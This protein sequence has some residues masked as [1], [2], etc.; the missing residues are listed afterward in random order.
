MVRSPDDARPDLLLATKLHMPPVPPDLVPRPSLV[1]R[2]AA[3][4]RRKLVLLLAPAGFG[5]TTLLSAALQEYARPT[6]WLSLDAGDND[7]ARFWAYVIA[8]VRTL[9]GPEGTLIGDE[10]LLMLRSPQAAP[11]EAVLTLLINALTAVPH[12]VTLVL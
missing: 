3:G 2:L 8:A 12:D 7:P 4:L 11:V 9:Q 6:A 5:K 10:A 1:T